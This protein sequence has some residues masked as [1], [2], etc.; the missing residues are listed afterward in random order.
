[1]N[2]YWGFKGIKGQMFFNMVVS[3]APH[4]RPGVDKVSLKDHTY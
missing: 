4:I 2:A 3:L 1:M